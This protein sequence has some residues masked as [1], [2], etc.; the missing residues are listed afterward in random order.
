MKL[1]A[2]AS[3]RTRTAGG[4]AGMRDMALCQW[5]VLRRAGH[6][7]VSRPAHRA[8]DLAALKRRRVWRPAAGVDAR[9][10]AE[11]AA[12]PARRGA[13]R[14]GRSAGWLSPGASDRKSIV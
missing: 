12:G 2:G 5:R 1:A 7:D 4:L 10:T 14:H 6:K 8:G 13:A 3:S 11:S 9:P